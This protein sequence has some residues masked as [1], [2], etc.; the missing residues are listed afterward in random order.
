MGWRDGMETL[1]RMVADEEKRQEQDKLNAKWAGQVRGHKEALDLLKELLS[2][3]NIA[4]T[5]TARTLINSMRPRL[6]HMELIP[7]KE[8]IHDRHTEAL[9]HEGGA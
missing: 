1:Q 9:H 3:K 5:K 7:V 8:G 4:D 2:Q 6:R